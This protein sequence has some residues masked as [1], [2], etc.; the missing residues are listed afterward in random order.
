MRIGRRFWWA[1]SAF[2][3]LIFSAYSAISVYLL[4]REIVA[5]QQSL[6]QLENLGDGA[7][8]LLTL[9]F[10]LCMIESEL[11]SWKRQKCRIEKSIYRGSKV[12]IPTR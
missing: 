5:R 6:W 7:F 12:N 1:G 3:I 8:L 4:L 9:C 2:V 10:S 11:R